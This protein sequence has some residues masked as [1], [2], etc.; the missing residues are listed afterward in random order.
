MTFQFQDISNGQLNNEFASWLVTSVFTDTCLELRIKNY[1]SGFWTALPG[2]E[3]EN[4]IA[5]ESYNSIAW[6][7]GQTKF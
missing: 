4:L 3:N 1:Q 5:S 6:S 2:T 7:L